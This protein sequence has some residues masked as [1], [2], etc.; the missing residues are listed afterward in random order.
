MIIILR[1]PSAIFLTICFQN[2][3]NKYGKKNMWVL[4]NTICFQNQNIKYVKKLC[5]C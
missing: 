2:Q 3:N 4:N 5:G 1:G